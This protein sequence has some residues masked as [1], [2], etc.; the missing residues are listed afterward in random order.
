MFFWTGSRMFAGAAE[1][2]LDP[3]VSFRIPGFGGRGGVA[4]QTRNRDQL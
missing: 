3:L 2:F 1:D 4:E